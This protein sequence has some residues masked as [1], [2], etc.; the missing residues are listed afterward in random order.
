MSKGRHGRASS[1]TFIRQSWS[2]ISIP[3]GNFFLLPDFETCEELYYPDIPFLWQEQQEKAQ[4]N[5]DDGDY[6]DTIEDNF[7]RVVINNCVGHWMGVI[8][9]EKALGQYPLPSPSP[10][11]LWELAVTGEHGPGGNDGRGIICC[12]LS[13]QQGMSLPPT[14]QE[15]L[16]KS[17][18]T[19]KG[20]F[21]FPAKQLLIA[22]FSCHHECPVKLETLSGL[23]HEHILGGSHLLVAKSARAVPSSVCTESAWSWK[24]PPAPWHQLSM[25]D[26]RSCFRLE[27]CLHSPAQPSQTLQSLGFH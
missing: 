26:F 23:S 15:L 5:N 9:W 16:L 4:A 20:T 13:T 8:T 7:T 1:P 3:F 11:R 12:W 14:A 22:N 17:R 2:N 10:P 6:S 18:D 25:L 19:E 24:L 27:L 21:P